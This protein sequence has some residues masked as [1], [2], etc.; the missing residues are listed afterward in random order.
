[1]EFVLGRWGQGRRKRGRRKRED[2]KRTGENEWMDP[3]GWKWVSTS[4]DG[5]TIENRM[6]LLG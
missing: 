1:M 4:R 6:F 5:E 2:E 3:G